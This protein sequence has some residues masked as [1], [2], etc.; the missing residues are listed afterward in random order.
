MGSLLIGSA[1]AS[2]RAL[3]RSEAKDY[4]KVKAVI[5]ARIL[6]GID[7]LPT[8]ILSY[9]EGRTAQAPVTGAEAKGSSGTLAPARR[10]FPQGGN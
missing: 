7:V 2:Y 1:Q 6:L 8:K 5:S 9:K 10:K 3:T 4:N